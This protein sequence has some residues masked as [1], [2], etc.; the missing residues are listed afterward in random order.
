MTWHSFFGA[1]YLPALRDLP[2]AYATVILAQGGY[3]L[4]IVRGWTRRS[5]GR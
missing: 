2:I 4:W 1:I 5:D 3:L